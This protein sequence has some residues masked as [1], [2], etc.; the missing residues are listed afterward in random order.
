MHKFH[1]RL[2]QKKFFIPERR[3]R[4]IVLYVTFLH[5]MCVL[6]SVSDCCSFL[7]FLLSLSRGTSMMLREKFLL[8]WLSLP[9]P[10]KKI[11]VIFHFM[12]NREKNS[13]LMLRLFLLDYT[14]NWYCNAVILIVFDII[15][16]RHTACRSVVF[17]CIF[18]YSCVY[19][20][21]CGCLSMT[22]KIEKKIVRNFNEFGNS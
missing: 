11:K 20:C 5:F 17:T 4:L 10:R 13:F 22:E 15:H 18:F 1:T 7:L 12:S 8:L 14:C 2:R 6:F 19:L 3:N 9:R 16:L 21:L